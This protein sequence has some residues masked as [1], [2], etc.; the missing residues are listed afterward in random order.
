M[1]KGKRKLILG[2]AFLCC[3]TFLVHTAIQEGAALTGVATTLGAMSA[4]VFGLVWGNVKDYQQAT[5]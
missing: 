2:L 3:S 1:F 4:G 5:E